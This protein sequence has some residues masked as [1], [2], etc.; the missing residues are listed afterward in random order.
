MDIVT[1]MVLAVL[2]ADAVGLLVLLAITIRERRD[3]VSLRGQRH[4][5]SRVSTRWTPVPLRCTQSP[6]IGI[7]R[8]AGE[9]VAC[10][11]NT[12]AR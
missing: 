8:G 1:P 12:G 3:A 4:P 11:G 7:E 5:P 10:N 2:A 6:V 9:T